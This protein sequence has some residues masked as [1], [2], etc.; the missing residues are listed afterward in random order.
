LSASTIDKVVSIS[1]DA[2]LAEGRVD[3]IVLTDD[4]DAGVVDKSIAECASAGVV[5]L[6]VGLVFGAA[7][8]EVLNNDETG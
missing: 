8:A 7:L 2:L 5:G 3:F 6:V 4:V 1:A